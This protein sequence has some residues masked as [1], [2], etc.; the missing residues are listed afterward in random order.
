MRFPDLAYVPHL[1][2]VLAETETKLQ[3]GWY[4]R[5]LWRR[6]RWLRAR[7]VVF[8]PLRPWQQAQHLELG[9][10]YILYHDRRVG[11]HAI[12]G[13][14]F[15]VSTL[16]DA[17]DAQLCISLPL[18]CHTTT[19]LCRSGNLPCRPC[20]GLSLGGAP[21]LL[22]QFGTGILTYVRNI[23]LQALDGLFAGISVECTYWFAF[24]RG[25]V[26][27]TDGYLAPSPTA[28]LPAF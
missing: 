24:H 20:L 2:L 26:V 21:G 25:F 11:A 23:I 3:A 15:V 18:C 19:F 5:C 16:Y 22:G 9:I 10:P 14:P 12:Q 28:S 13:L 7:Q 6:V 27:L 17:S 8:R 1:F 4:Q